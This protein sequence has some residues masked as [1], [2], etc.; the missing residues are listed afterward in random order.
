MRAGG[1]N[2]E[3]DQFCPEEQDEENYQFHQSNELYFEGSQVEAVILED[4]LQECFENISACSFVVP[5]YTA[6]GDH[7]KRRDNNIM[8]SVNQ[9]DKGQFV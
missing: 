8:L 2:S 1:E 7:T 9:L 6:A 4:L 5:A 3:I